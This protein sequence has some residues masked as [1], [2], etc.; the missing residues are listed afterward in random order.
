MYIEVYAVY[1]SILRQTANVYRDSKYIAF[2]ARAIMIVMPDVHARCTSL[3]SYDK[4]ATSAS[5][6]HIML[7]IA[8]M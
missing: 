6:T 8:F 1:L 2:I 5:T 4:H 3:L 7:A